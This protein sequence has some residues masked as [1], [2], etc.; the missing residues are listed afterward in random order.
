MQC[1]ECMHQVLNDP[2]QAVFSSDMGHFVSDNHFP[3]GKRP[4][5][6]LFRDV[7]SR[8]NQ[9]KCQRYLN[10]IGLKNRN[11]PPVVIKRDQFRGA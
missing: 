7:N 2:E 11:M 5:V 1:I 10:F 9:S 3:A 8:M 6:P 4:V